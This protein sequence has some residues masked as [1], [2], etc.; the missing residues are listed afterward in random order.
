[1]KNPIRKLDEKLGHT[2]KTEDENDGT[3]AQSEA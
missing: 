2:I 1:V 3:A